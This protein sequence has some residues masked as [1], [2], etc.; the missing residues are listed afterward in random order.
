VLLAHDP[1]DKA[2]IANDTSGDLSNLWRVLGGP[3][4]GRL[5]SEVIRHPFSRLRWMKAIE[6]LRVK[7][8][9]IPWDCWTED[10]QVRRAVAYYVVAR[11]SMAGRF[12][13]NPTFAPI[14]QTRLRSMMNE[15]VSAWW[16]AIDKLDLVHARLSRVLVECQ[17]VMKLLPRWDKPRVLVYLDPPWIKATRA[18][19]DVYEHEMTEEQHRR[20]LV[21]ICSFTKAHVCVS[22]RPH[23]LYDFLLAR[24]NR[25]DLTHKSSA[26]G[27]KVKK[28]M[29]HTVWTNY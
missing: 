16:G 22:G 3:L 5:K 14:T 15:Q 7:C 20:L 4:F 12:G 28:T 23:P 19:K 1:T 6:S 2:E 25:T 29:T 18:T 9:T 11:Q 17:D 8:P 13:K 10:M 24:W 27:G 26:G 21:L